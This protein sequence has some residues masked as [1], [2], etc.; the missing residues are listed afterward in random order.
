MFFAVMLLCCSLVTAFSEN[1]IKLDNA[2]NDFATDLV[3]RLSSSQFPRNK[4]AVVSFGTDSQELMEYFF[5]IMVEKVR[6][7]G[8]DIYERRELEPLLKELGFSLTRYADK[9]SAQEIGKLV[10]ADAV[11]YGSIASLSKNNAGNDFMMTITGAITE[12]GQIVSHKNYY[13]KLDSRLEDLLGINITRLW[14]IG[15]SG[16]SSILTPPLL[17]VTIHGTLA[18]L[19]YS[20]FEF[21]LDGG[22]ISTDQDEEYYSLCPF[23]HFAL[24]F[25]IDKVGLYAGAGASYLYEVFKYKYGGEDR[26]PFFLLDGIVGINIM[27]NLDVSYTIRMRKDFSSYKQH[28]FSVG[29]TCRFK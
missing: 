22:I 11:I 2:I 8:G 28:K 14:T 5:R 15:I 6:E 21:G 12:T 24:F 27:N 4:T 20:F 18:P 9:E 1:K 29:Y 13:L 10:G 16:G 3:S 23:A 7:E 25:P 19:R 17:I 26:T